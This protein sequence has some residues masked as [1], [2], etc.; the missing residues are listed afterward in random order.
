ML[1][2]VKI[3]AEFN[4]NG[5]EKTLNH[6]LMVDTQDQ[7]QS[8]IEVLVSEY[9]FRAYDNISYYTIKIKGW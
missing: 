5:K 9:L 4:T 2:L 3:I 1:K 7:T 8:D 6:M